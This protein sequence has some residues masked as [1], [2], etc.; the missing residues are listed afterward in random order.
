MYAQYTHI[1]LQVPALALL[2][3]IVEARGL[4]HA[5]A[6]CYAM[7]DMTTSV[8]FVAGPVFGSVC[9]DTFGFGVTFGFAAVACALTALSTLMLR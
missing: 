1:L 7:Q 4:Q 8:A 3:E 6:S 9:Y 2:P 5:Y